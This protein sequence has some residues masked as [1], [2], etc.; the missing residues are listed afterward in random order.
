MKVSWQGISNIRCP[1]RFLRKAKRPGNLGGWRNYVE[2][3]GD[4][5]RAL[6]YNEI[7]KGGNVPLQSN[8]T[9][10]FYTRVIFQFTILRFSFACSS[11][12][13]YVV[14]QLVHVTRTVFKLRGKES[15]ICQNRS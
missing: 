14:Q 11:T 8:L 15:G 12:H 6:Y 3:T 2:E 5:A 10:K 13:I 4:F 1:P 9:G 7:K